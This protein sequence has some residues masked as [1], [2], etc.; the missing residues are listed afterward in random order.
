MTSSSCPKEK[1][2]KQRLDQHTIPWVTRTFQIPRAT[3]RKNHDVPSV[4]ACQ[5][6]I[7]TFNGILRTSPVQRREKF[8]LGS[9]SSSCRRKST[10]MVAG[11]PRQFLICASP[12]HH[13]CRYLAREKL[14]HG[15]DSQLSHSQPNHA[16]SSTQAPMRL[17]QNHLPNNL[18]QKVTKETKH[19]NPK[20]PHKSDHPN[21]P[22][23]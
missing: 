4:C 21:G 5:R 13:L 12:L 8:S 17:N 6:S 15:L 7:A 20:Q 14:S 1:R 9:C 10:C 2:N 16:S 3:T 18:K 22:F 11:I 19:Q 23:L